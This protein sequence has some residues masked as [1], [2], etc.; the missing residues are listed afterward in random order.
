MRL[1][2]LK[3]G[4]HVCQIVVLKTSK[5]VKPSLKHAVIHVYARSFCDVNI[6]KNGVAFKEF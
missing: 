5:R 6:I 3:N 2:G 4:T 1:G